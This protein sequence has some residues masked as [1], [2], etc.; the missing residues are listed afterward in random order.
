MFYPK[1]SNLNGESELELREGLVK[2]RLSKNY[3][4]SFIS[5][6]NHSDKNMF[7]K[8]GEI[9]GGLSTDV[10][11]G[12]LG[13]PI[14]LVNNVAQDHKSKQKSIGSRLRKF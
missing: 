4:Y 10:E 6:I 13:E 1:E 2:V 5:Y 7:L 11:M 9:I 3:M 12:E 8:R 14:K